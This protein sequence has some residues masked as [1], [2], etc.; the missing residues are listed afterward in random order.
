MDRVEWKADDRFVERY[1]LPRLLQL[2]ECRSSSAD[3]IPLD[4]WAAFITDDLLDII[5]LSL[6]VS[7]SAT[8]LAALVGLPLGGILAVYEFRGRRALTILLNGLLGLPPVVVGLALYLLLSRSGPLGWLGLLFTPGGMIV[9]QATLAMPIIGALA[10]RATQGPWHEYGDALRVDGASRPRVIRM[11]LVI[12]R[13]PVL[14]A[15]LAGFGRTIS[16]VGAILIVGGNIAGY[17][18]TMTTTIVLETSKGNLPVAI[19]LGLVLS[20][21]SIAVSATGLLIG[22]KGEE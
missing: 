11:L 6:G 22:E 12:A 7:L 14:T 4:L 5:G 8:F 21:L 15:V 10:H 20:G 19:G 18:R 17:T 3:D 13:P 2:T 1:S 16:E 9:A